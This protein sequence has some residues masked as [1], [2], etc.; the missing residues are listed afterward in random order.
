MK[1]FSLLVKPASADCN[2]R[3]AYCFYL[4][5]SALYPETKKHRMSDEVLERMIRSYMKTEQP[6]YAFG[7]QGGE[8]TLMGVE[9]FQKVVDLQKHHGKSGSSVSNGLQTNATLIN[10]ELAAHLAKYHFLVGASIDGPPEF[11]NTYRRTASGKSTHDA[12]LKGIDALNRYNVEYNGLILVS[13]ANVGHPEQV[14]QYLRDLGIY[15]HQYI[16]CVEFDKKG[17]ALPYSITGEQWGAFLSTIFDLWIKND[18]RKISIRTFDA[19]LGQMVDGRY[20]M[21]TQSGNCTSYFVVEYNGDVYPCDFFVEKTK[22][23]GNIV[24]DGW[25]TFQNSKKYRSFG[26][27]KSEWSQVCSSCQFLRYCSGDCPK[28]R[29]VENRNPENLS[30]LCAGW[31]QFYGHT[32]SDFERIAVALLNERQYSLP[33]NERRNYTRVQHIKIGWNDACHCGSGKKYRLCHG[34]AV[35]NKSR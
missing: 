4:D 20:T 2:L 28:Q 33:A 30:W 13:A 22:K 15:F 9:F 3:C 32:L 18:T 5:R 17:N 6:T 19:I 1:P 8:P 14:Y 12:V 23:I 27:Q 35:S 7:W 11:H 26:I 25:E 10:D 21:C 24:R 29:Y 34:T 31:K 16:P